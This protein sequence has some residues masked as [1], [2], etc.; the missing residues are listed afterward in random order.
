MGCWEVLELEPRDPS[1]IQQVTAA[2]GGPVLEPG[3]GSA[4][5]I[6]SAKASRAA[7]R[8]VLGSAPLLPVLGGRTVQ[9]HGSECSNAPVL[10]VSSFARGLQLRGRPCSAWV[11]LMPCL[12]FPLRAL[13]LLT[14]GLVLGPATK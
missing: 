3:G 4:G 12:L 9:G 14:V 13:N 6:E 1:T 7:E 2:P 10:P 5:E 8:K 11:P